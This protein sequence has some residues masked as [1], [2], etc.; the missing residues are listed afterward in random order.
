LSEVFIRHGGC[1]RGGQLFRFTKEKISNL[2]ELN[3]NTSTKSVSSIGVKTN[4]PRAKTFSLRVK[5]AIKAGGF[6]SRS[7]NH[8]P[9][10]VRVS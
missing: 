3:V 4:T 2:K 6:N 9:V 5:T 7:F 1:T 10:L 8:N